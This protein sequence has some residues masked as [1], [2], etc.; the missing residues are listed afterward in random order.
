M[1]SWSYSTYVKLAD[2]H[3]MDY[4]FDLARKFKLCHMPLYGLN[5]N[6]YF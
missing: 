5:V 2:C 6:I 1:M 3:L 4:V